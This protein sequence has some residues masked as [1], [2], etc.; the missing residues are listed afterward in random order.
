MLWQDI[1]NWKYYNNSCVENKVP[2]TFFFSKISF[3]VE[4]LLY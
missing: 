2:W 3:E 1:E 4:S